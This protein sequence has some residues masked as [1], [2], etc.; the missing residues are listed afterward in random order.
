MTTFKN[1]TVFITGGTRGIGKAIGLKL[2]AEGAKIVIAAKTTEPHPKLEGTIYSAAEDMIKAGGEALAIKCDIREEEQVQQAVDETVKTFGGID[3]LINNASAI[4]LFPTL[5]LPMKNYDL[6]QDINTRGTFM[7]SQKCIPH[8]KKAPNPHILTLSPPLNLDK[9]WFGQHV[10]YTISKYGMSMCVLGMAEE[11]RKDGI[12]INALWPATTIATAAVQ[13]I[14]GGE[15]L[16]NR[17]RTPQIVAD[18]AYFVLSSDSKTTSGNFFIDEQVLNANG[19]SDFSHYN[20]VPG[21]QL[22][23]DIFL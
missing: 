21:A 15:E 18:A 16:M 7:V 20:Q 5:A 2:A 8:L 3:I 23:P 19:I 17:S 9:K 13:N 6:M 12:A 1:K 22:M 11:F 10:A 4:N 14:I